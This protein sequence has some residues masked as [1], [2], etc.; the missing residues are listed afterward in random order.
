L[1]EEIMLANNLNVRQLFE[2]V[3]VVQEPIG[4]G[5]LFNRVP[6]ERASAGKVVFFEGDRADNVFAIL[7]GNLRICRLLHDG[8]RVITGF[9]AKGDIVGVSFKNRYL[10]S[11]EA[12]DDVSFQRRTKASFEQQLRV[13]PELRPVLL[14]QLRDEVA[15]AQDQMVLLSCKSAEERLCS[16]LLN[17]LE[18][19]ASHVADPAAICL[20]MTRLDIADYL[21]LTIETVSRTITKL[22]GMNVI[23]VSGRYGIVVRNKSAL[24]HRAGDSQADVDE[25]FRFDETPMRHHH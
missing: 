10:Y 21:G 3:S 17:R 11:A 7:E 15:A 25:D 19:G 1:E 12:I 2:Q 6:V 20:P 14:S 4:L 22:V 9:L 5:A 18:K 13:R 16:F 23:S 8:R 24:V